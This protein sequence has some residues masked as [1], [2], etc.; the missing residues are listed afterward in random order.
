MKSGGVYT[1]RTMSCEP[2]LLHVH[3]SHGAE[4]ELE[5][6][7][8]RLDAGTMRSVGI[9]ALSGSDSCPTQRARRR[10]ATYVPPNR[11]LRSA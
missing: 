4:L 1:S 8:S 5:R 3:R 7:T 6:R 11:L 2:R 10:T 9:I